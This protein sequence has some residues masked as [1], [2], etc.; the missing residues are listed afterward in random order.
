MSAAVNQNESLIER[1]LRMYAAGSITAE[2]LGENL[3]NSL[4]Y[5]ELFGEVRDSV[6]RLPPEAA[7]AAVRLSRQILTPDW[8]WIPWG[9]GSSPTA[10]Q[11]ERL[12]V[13]LKQVAAE[14]LATLTTDQAEPGVISGGVV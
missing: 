5:R 9:V 1:R 8:R 11:R 4:A 2:E 14:V 7:A 10:E 12:L 6:R 3:V 13:A